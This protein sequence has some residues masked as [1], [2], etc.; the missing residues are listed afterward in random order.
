MEA[1]LRMV[2]ERLVREG[3]RAVEIVRLPEPAHPELTEL[4]ELIAGE[5]SVAGSGV[6]AFFKRALQYLVGRLTRPFL[7]R[8]RAVNTRVQEGL[9]RVNESLTDLDEHLLRGRAGAPAPPG[10]ALWRDARAHARAG[11]ERARRA[12]GLRGA[13]TRR[14][15]VAARRA[16][17]ARPGGPPTGA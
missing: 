7:G 2:H 8:Q 4:G 15:G 14:G 17:G 3:A 12:G 6:G 5:P 11:R 1:R 16:R 13:R 9:A 10:G